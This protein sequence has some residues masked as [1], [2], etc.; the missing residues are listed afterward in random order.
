LASSRRVSMALDEVSCAKT[1]ATH[2]QISSIVTICTVLFIIFS[3]LK[4]IKYYSFKNPVSFCIYLNET[5]KAF[6]AV[7]GSATNRRFKGS[8]YRFP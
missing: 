2:R 1:G 3:I 6:S 7:P 4:V 8:G 5:L